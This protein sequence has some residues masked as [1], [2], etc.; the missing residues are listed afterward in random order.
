[1]RPVPHPQM[2]IGEVRTEDMERNPKS[3]DDLPA[4]LAGRQHRYGDRDL[5]SRLFGL[6]E[7]HLVLDRDHGTGVRA[8]RGGGCG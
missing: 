8:W 3:R 4:L 5:R 6:L 1:M 7:A 2:T